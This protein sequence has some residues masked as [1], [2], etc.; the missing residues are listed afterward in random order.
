MQPAHLRHSPDGQAS[1]LHRPT[2]AA[3]SAVAVRALPDGLATPRAAADLSSAEPTDP[4]TEGP[5]GTPLL[6]TALVM[7]AIALK[8]GSR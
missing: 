6:A 7:L 2:D 3:A 5:L 8:R 4:P 1:A